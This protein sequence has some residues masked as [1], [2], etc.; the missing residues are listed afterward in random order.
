MRREAAAID[1]PIGVRLLRGGAVTQRDIVEV[2]EA[3]GESSHRR[4]GIEMRFGRKEQGVFEAPRK[5]GFEL[6]DPP[7][8]DAF[9]SAGAAGKADELGPVPRGGDD[10]RSL[11]RRDRHAFSP[12]LEPFQAEIE[13]E[14]FRAL[15]LA[16][17]RQHAAREMRTA[18]TRTFAA[19]DEF[20]IATRAGELNAAV[21]PAMPAPISNAH[22]FTLLHLAAAQAKEARTDDFLRGTSRDHPYASTSWIRFEGSPGRF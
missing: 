9:I 20:D 16:P 19:F 4:A 2:L 12:I 3:R 7:R 18:E 13:D 22:G 1:R 15:G 6:R 11:A 21:K 14:L 5:I 10:E 8:V 17:G